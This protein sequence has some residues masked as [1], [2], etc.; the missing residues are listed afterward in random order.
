MSKVR[1]AMIQ[2]ASR[3]L[4]KEYNLDRAEKL[5]RSAAEQGAQI[6]CLPELFGCGYYLPV[7][8][9]H[10]EELCEE[11]DGETVTRLKEL[12]SELGVAICAGVMLRANNGG[13]LN[14]AVLTDKNGQAY[15]YSKQHM[16]G[17]EGKYFTCEG[18]Y[19]TAETGFGKVGVII[20][21]DNNFSEPASECAKMGAELVLCPCAWREQ[22]KALFKEMTTSHAKENG[23]YLCSVN[24]F[25]QF[26]E[27]KLFG[28]SITAD[29][30][31]NVIA[32]CSEGE[33]VV[34][35]DICLQTDSSALKE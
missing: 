9:K 5:I 30:L 34:I 35:C 14:G 6:M 1:L 25:G 29:P 18:G 32:E 10:L 27:L 19:V 15:F 31:G 8:G 7:L 12:S 24:M 23:I 20:C 22:D 4:D 21:F 2:T 11:R 16:F 13:V 33:E 17:D 26:E 28:G 3:L